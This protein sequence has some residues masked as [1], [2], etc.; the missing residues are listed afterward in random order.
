MF[1]LF[2]QLLV[3]MLAHLFLTPFYNA[4]HELTSFAQ[5]IFKCNLKRLQP[6]ITRG[7]QRSVYVPLPG[8]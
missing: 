5:I 6:D 4:P 2:E 8:P 7:G 1:G 3:F